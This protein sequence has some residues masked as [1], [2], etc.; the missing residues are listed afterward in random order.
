M[1]PAPTP[2]SV[3]YFL[4]YL[5]VASFSRSDNYGAQS[6]GMAPQNPLTQKFSAGGYPPPLQ[7]GVVIGTQWVESMEAAHWPPV[8]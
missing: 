4:C 7:P 1:T 3:N 2:G 6:L 8:H 5:S